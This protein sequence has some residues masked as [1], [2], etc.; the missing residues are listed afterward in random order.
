[1]VPLPEKK[2][3][4]QEIGLRIWNEDKSAVLVYLL[5]KSTTWT[6]PTIKDKGVLDTLSEQLLNVDIASAICIVNTKDSVTLI[7]GTSV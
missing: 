6:L 5:N 1:M 7:C 3:M 2:E 4:K